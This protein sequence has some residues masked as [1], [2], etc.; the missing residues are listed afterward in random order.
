M[1]LLTYKE[2]ETGPDAPPNPSLGHRAWRWLLSLSPTVVTF[3]V[4]FS[5]G[6]G[7]VGAQTSSMTALVLMAIFWGLTVI[8]LVGVVARWMTPGRGRHR[9]AAS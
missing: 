4:A 1:D 2:A 5:I 8:A 7:M 3:M 9:M 6:L